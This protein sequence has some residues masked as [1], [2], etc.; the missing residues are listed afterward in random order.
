[1]WLVELIDFDVLDIDSYL[2]MIEVVFFG[3]D[4]D[5]VIVVFGLFGDVEELW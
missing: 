3:G 1:M 4:V 5:V 2:K